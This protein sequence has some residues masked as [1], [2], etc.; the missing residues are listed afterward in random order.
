MAPQAA[1][2]SAALGRLVQQ[3]DELQTWLQS[4]SEGRALSPEDA[5]TTV[6]ALEKVEECLTLTLT[7]HHSPLTLTLT[8]TLILTLTLTLT[9]LPPLLLAAKGSLSL[10][11][12]K[13]H[14][15]LSS[16][17]EVLRRSG[18]VLGLLASGELEVTVQQTLPLT[19][20]G[21]RQGHR[22]LEARG[23]VGKILFSIE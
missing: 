5:R 20:E 11:R 18:E 8:L 9:A 2:Y 22:L 13:L 16:R 4:S 23:T 12:P 17:E 10:T 21:V 14:D 15:F 1:T 19:E 7:A 6:D 3:M